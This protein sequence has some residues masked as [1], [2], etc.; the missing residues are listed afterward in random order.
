ML[1]AVMGGPCFAPLLGICLQFRPLL[2]GSGPLPHCR[3]GGRR[4]AAAGAGARID[5]PRLG[6]LS[7]EK[8]TSVLAFLQVPK[9]TSGWPPQHRYSGAQL[10][11]L[12]G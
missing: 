2:P 9:T 6:R 8:R 11:R 5:E 10:L 12:R 7:L 4:E 1:Y 3:R